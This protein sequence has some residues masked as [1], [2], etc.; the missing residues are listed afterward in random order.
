ML[1]LFFVTAVNA[2]IGVSKLRGPSLDH[3]TDKDVKS[4]GAAMQAATE[5]VKTDTL[6]RLISKTFS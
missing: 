5:Q 4:I 6:L 1:P 2:A 3:T